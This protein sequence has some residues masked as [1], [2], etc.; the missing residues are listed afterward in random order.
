MR[1]NLND[2]LLLYNLCK[3]I[4]NLLP[5]FKLLQINTQRSKLWSKPYRRSG[6]TSV[7]VGVRYASAA[8]A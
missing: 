3:V 1:N 8:E 5:R 7:H 6:G 4:L 2:N